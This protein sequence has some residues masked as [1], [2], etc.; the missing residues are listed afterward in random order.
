MV[1]DKMNHDIGQRIAQGLA[2]I[3]IAQRQQA[4]AAGSERNLT[5]TQAQMLSQLAS[6]GPLRLKELAAQLAITP[7]TASDSVRVLVEKKL[8]SKKA[9]ATD[10]RAVELGLT[11]AGRREAKRVAQ[12]PDFLVQAI[13]VLSMEDRAAFLRGLVKMIATLQERGEIPV[14]RMCSSCKFFRPHVYRDVNQPH[15]CDFVDAP[16][17]DGGLQTDC[18]DH[19]AAPEAR[20]REL[21]QVFVNGQPATS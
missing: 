8:V 5:P 4:W 10:R 2:R 3:G 18:P 21:L 12:W 20:R 11:A 19:D 1:V 16:F 7:A 13:D 15:H 14:T 6:A 9:A 17:G